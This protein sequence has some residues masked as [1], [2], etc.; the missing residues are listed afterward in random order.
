MDVI[1]VMI[2]GA[3]LGGVSGALWAGGI[4]LLIVLVIAGLT[5]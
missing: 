3:I 2:L 4:Y 5:S 1:L